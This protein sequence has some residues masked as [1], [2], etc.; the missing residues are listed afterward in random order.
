MPAAKAAHPAAAEAAHAAVKAAEA[1]AKPAMTELGVGGV[2]DKLRVADIAS[3]ASPA[4]IFL[5]I[6]LRMFHLRKPAL[7]LG[8][9]PGRDRVAPDAA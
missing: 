6:E 5:E 3:A 8:R 9:E 7:G 4:T 1:A 2:V